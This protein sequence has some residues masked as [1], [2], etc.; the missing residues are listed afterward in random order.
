MPVS[1]GRS[2][3]LFLSYAHNDN[4]PLVPG[5]SGWVENFQHTLK[6]RLTQILGREPR[7][8]WDRSAM[9]GNDVIGSAIDQGIERSSVMVAIV[10]PSY[11]DF[12]RS[13]WCRKELESFRAAAERLGVPPDVRNRIFKVV[14]TQVDLDRQPPLL[15]DLRGYEFYRKDPATGRPREFFLQPAAPLDP[16]YIEKIDDLAEDIN[17]F[18]SGLDAAATAPPATAAPVEAAAPTVLFLAETTSDLTADREQLERM[19][20]QAGYVVL[21]DRDLPIARGPALR[22]SVRESLGRAAL[23]IHLIGANYGTVPESETE[24]VTAIQNELAAER[25]ADPSFCRLIWIPADVQPADQRQRQFLERLRTDP[26][27]QRGAE[28]LHAGLTDLERE[29]RNRLQRRPARQDGGT[30]GLDRGD[31]SRDLYLICYKR[32]R[33]AAQGLREAIRAAWP[34]VNVWLPP[35]Q[36]DEADIRALHREYLT[37]CD[38]VLLF[39]AEAPPEWLDVKLAELKK[40]RAFGRERPLPAPVI[41]LAPPAAQTTL[42]GRTDAATV[43]IGAATPSVAPLV[44][45]AGHLGLEPAS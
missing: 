36:G 37:L 21:P 23:S 38:C 7:L 19:L 2:A 24:S 31:P 26:E 12:E 44:P 3:A 27:A 17:R 1:R 16:A 13:D 33:A 35:D 40:A 4:Q 5:Q 42:P 11:V 43:V 28:I 8:W 45:V 6:V 30:N 32:D 9:G 39:R 15:K 25:A 29:I 10:S 14:K 22:E 20:R 34:A 41:Y 18:V